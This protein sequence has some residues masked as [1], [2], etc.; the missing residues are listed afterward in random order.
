MVEPLRHRQT[1]GAATDMFHLPPPRH[2]STLPKTEG[3]AFRRYVCLSPTGRHS[4]VRPSVLVDFA[5]N[6]NRSAIY[7]YALMTLETPLVRHR[8]DWPVSEPESAPTFSLALSA[9]W[10]GTTERGSLC[11]RRQSFRSSS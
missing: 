6:R 9:C 3:S 8:R 4:L 7:T 10:A 5:T 1:K 2:I 11:A